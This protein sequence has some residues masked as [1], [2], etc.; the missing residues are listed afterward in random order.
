MKLRYSVAFATP[1]ILQRCFP[2]LKK[3]H[4]ANLENSTQIIKKGTLHVYSDGY[5]NIELFPADDLPRGY[6]KALKAPLSDA[7]LL[8][9]GG[10]TQTNAKDFLADGFDGIGV[11]SNLY[12]KE[13]IG[14][15]NFTALENLAKEYVFAVKKA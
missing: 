4:Q 7:R 10:I 3:Y 1:H 15:K 6:I 9:V 14:A 12:C 8:A 2:A 5:G 13:L 11:G